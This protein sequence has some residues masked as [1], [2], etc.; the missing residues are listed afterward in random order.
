MHISLCQTI[1]MR[2]ESKSLF[3]IDVEKQLT[4]INTL[5]IDNFESQRNYA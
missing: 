4:M 1:K 3:S 2:H 5:I